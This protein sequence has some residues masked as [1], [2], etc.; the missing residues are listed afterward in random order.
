MVRVAPCTAFA[1]AQGLEHYGDSPIF[2]DDWLGT[3]SPDNGFHTVDKGRWA[4][5]PVMTVS[6]HRHSTSAQR[7][8]R[9]RLRV[10]ESLL[11]L[12][13]FSVSEPLARVFPLLLC[14]SH[15]LVRFVFAICA[16]IEYVARF[17]ATTI[18]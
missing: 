9:P 4:Y 5:L 2:A 18:Q 15:A 16:A 11:G 6:R 1:A 12:Y 3:A 8:R 17:A 10:G 7:R 14:G 13:V